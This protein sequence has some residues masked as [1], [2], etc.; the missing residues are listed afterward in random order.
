M[1]KEVSVFLRLDLQL[2]GESLSVIDAVIL[3]T[4]HDPWPEDSRDFGAAVK[5]ARQRL[6][7]SQPKFAKRLGV[8]KMTVRN[9]ENG[10][11]PPSAKTRALIVEFLTEQGQFPIGTKRDRQNT[12]DAIDAA[13]STLRA[14]A[15]GLPKPTKS[16][17][18]ID[19]KA[20]S[21]SPA[22]D[23]KKEEP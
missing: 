14:Q 1:S 18:T 12:A 7:L 8:T 23:G 17:P 20:P 5:L 2:D 10:H 16:P 6:G 15:V 3:K 22:T 4:V 11:N 21:Q 13:I 9:L 19:A